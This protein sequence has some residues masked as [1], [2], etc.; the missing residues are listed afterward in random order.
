MIK[1]PDTSRQISENSSVISD[2]NVPLPFAGRGSDDWFLNICETGGKP[3]DILRLPG[4][5]SVAWLRQ[6]A[7]VTLWTPG[8]SLNGKHLRDSNGC[9]ALRKQN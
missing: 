8:C 1:P 6:C 4:S 3:V 2:K 5:Y 9:C 7:P